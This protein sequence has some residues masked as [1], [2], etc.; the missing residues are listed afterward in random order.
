MSPPT[1]QAPAH[2]GWWPDPRPEIRG[3]HP[4]CPKGVVSV[5]P[6]THTEDADSTNTAASPDATIIMLSCPSPA[7]RPGELRD[8]TE[9]RADPPDCSGSDLV[10]ARLSLRIGGGGGGNPEG[11]GRMRFSRSGTRDRPIGVYED[12]AAIHGE[13]RHASGSRTFAALGLDRGGCCGAC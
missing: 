12:K 4:A 10:G 2:I 8:G 11:G 1:G 3:D 5:T 6:T 13:A 9:F 7:S